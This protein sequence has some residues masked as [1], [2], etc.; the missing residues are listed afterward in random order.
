MS[1]RVSGMTA[2]QAAL[3]DGGV[4][5]RL[6]GT[7]LVIVR[8]GGPDGRPQICH[9]P[10]QDTGEVTYD[11]TTQTYAASGVTPT[12]F[13]QDAAILAERPG[14]RAAVTRRVVSIAQA[15]V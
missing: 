7:D 5:V 15:G 14:G 8:M 11:A 6:A 3:G 1:R 4:S 2:E 13:V 12:T 10:R 9:L